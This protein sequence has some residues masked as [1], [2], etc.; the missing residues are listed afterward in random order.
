[1][2]FT[3]RVATGVETVQ[4]V[5]KLR[6]LRRQRSGD[7][8]DVRKYRRLEPLG[9]G[10]GEPTDGALGAACLADGE[11]RPEPRT[12]RLD[13]VDSADRRALGIPEAQHAA[14]E[15]NTCRASAE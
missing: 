7:A 11:S 2:S 14:I 10:A 6:E 8:G 9:L 12:S 1:M 5:V 3:H 4:A 15:R 13:A